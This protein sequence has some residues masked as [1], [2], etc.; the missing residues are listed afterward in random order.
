MDWHET[1]TWNLV[2][3]GWDGWDGIAQ[4]KGSRVMGGLVQLYEID[5][6]LTQLW[7]G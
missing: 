7:I 4:G 1:G 6:L 2:G 5:G 3:S